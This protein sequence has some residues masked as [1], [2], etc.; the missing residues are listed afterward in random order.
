[1]SKQQSNVL[2]RKSIKIIYS[3]KRSENSDGYRKREHSCKMHESVNRLQTY[4][5]LSAELS[6]S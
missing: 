3:V 4:D 2:A 6:A 1:L 5:Q